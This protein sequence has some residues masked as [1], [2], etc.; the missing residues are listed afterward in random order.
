MAQILP[1]KTDE[2]VTQFTTAYVI[3]VYHTN[4]IYMFKVC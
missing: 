4:N 2:L 1:D 3:D